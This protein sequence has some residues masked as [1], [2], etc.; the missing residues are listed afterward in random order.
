MNKF[1]SKIDDLVNGEDRPKPQKIVPRKS[2][3]DAPPE[4]PAKTD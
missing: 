2:P 4:V 1:V 3:A